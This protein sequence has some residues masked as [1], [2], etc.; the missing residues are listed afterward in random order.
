MELGIYVLN[1]TDVLLHFE[2]IETLIE[3]ERIEW[4]ASHG[5]YIDDN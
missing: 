3:M 2:H 1:A 5:K 4:K